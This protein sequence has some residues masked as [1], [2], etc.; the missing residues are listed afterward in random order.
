MAVRTAVSLACFVLWVAC[1]QSKLQGGQGQLVAPASLDFGTVF[2]GATP[3]RQLSLGNGGDAQL[4]LSAVVK[5]DPQV[6]LSS[7][8]DFTVAEGASAAVSITLAATQVGPVSATLSIAGDATALVPITANVLAD[9]SCPQS[10]A[11]NVQTFDPNAGTC[12]GSP[13]ADG[14]SCNDGNLCEADETCIGGVCKGSAL[15]C[16]DQNVCTTDYCTAAQGCQHLDNSASC[17]GTNPCQI[18]Y[19]DPVKG[20]QSTQ[21]SDG[22][23]CSA[24]IQCQ[25]A[26]VCFQGQCVGVAVPDGTPCV[27]PKDPCAKDAT[28]RSG[29]C[30]SPTADALQPG[31]ILWKAVASELSDGDGGELPYDGGNVPGWRAAAAVDALGDLYLD[32][33]DWD[34]GGSLVSLDVCGQE[35]WRTNQWGPSSNA[36]TNGRHLLMDDGAIVVTVA[37]D[38]SF[39]AQSTTDGQ[40]LWRDDL[41]GAGLNV[42][43]LQGFMIKDIA[44]SNDDVFYFTAEWFQSDGDGGTDMYGLVGGLLANGQTKFAVIEPAF[45]YATG[46]PSF[47]YPLL[48]DAN[49]DLYTVLDHGDGNAAIQSFDQTGGL[50]WTLP[51]S[52]GGLNSLSDDQGL[53]LEPTS[54]TAF[55]SNGAVQWSDTEPATV[56]VPTGHSPIV[57]VDGTEVVTRERDGGSSWYG[58]IESYAA[59]GAPGWTFP[60]PAGEFPVSSHVLDTQGDIYFA[61]NRERLVALD[62]TAGKLTWQMDLPTQ[63]PMYM[64]VMALTPASSLVVSARRELFSVYAGAPMASSPWPRFRGDNQNR[65]CPLPSAPGGG[66]SPSP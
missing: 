14:T 47:G 51:V 15:T 17:Q 64:G 11:C 65:S 22:T 35:R 38:Q 8:R 10:V 48:V 42:A 54:M 26:T 19:C 61:T 50:R 12:I 30:D 40:L 45:D 3:V 53:F 58:T 28:C 52:R 36:W 2:V 24:E 25:Q 21:A 16:D 56:V 6:S 39:L 59:G 44:L 13:A 1:S 18:Y 7:A 66:G 55:D 60:L 32:D 31:D 9:L 4:S 33:D 23:P 46:W 20:C 27:A 63:G 43:A 29:Q 49:E 62:G 34:G 5:G 41:T 37:A 57:E